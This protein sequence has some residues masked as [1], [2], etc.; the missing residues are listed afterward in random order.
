MRRIEWL[1]SVFVW[2]MRVRAGTSEPVPVGARTHE[3]ISDLA[4]RGAARM[5]AV[6][7]QGID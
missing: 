7:V 6:A 1:H 5:C 4:A 3:A 2:A